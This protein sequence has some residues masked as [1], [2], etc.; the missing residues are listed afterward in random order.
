MPTGFF[1]PSP[2]RIALSRAFAMALPI[3]V[4]IS[5]ARAA[6][7]SSS[8]A[9][10]IATKPPTLY[11][12]TSTW[13]NVRFSSFRLAH[14]SVQ[15]PSEILPM[16]FWRPLP[17]TLRR[18]TNGSSLEVAAISSRTRPSMTSGMVRPTPVRARFSAIAE[19][20]SPR[21]LRTL[22]FSRNAARSC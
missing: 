16:T 1:E 9:L 15:T 13:L 17:L 6:S 7:L 4:M 2:N 22:S 3:A 21:K 20:T 5:F 19:R 8:T 10:Q 12:S 18:S 11:P 14:I